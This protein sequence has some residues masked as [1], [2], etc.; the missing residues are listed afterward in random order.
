VL[1]ERECGASQGFNPTPPPPLPPPPRSF[2][3]AFDATTGA[4]SQLTD[5]ATGE[6]WAQ[7]AVDGSALSWLEYVNANQTECDFYCSSYSYV[8]PPPS[9]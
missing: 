2:T 5:T 4:I 3:I 6:V 7:A 9:W 1:L 8:Q